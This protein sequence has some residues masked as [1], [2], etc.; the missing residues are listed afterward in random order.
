M[1]VDEGNDDDEKEDYFAHGQQIVLHEDKQYYPEA[2]K[3]FGKGVE[4]LVMEEDAQPLD[5]PIIAPPK[6]ANFQ[7]YERDALEPTYSMEFLGSMS[8]KADLTRSIAICGHLHNGKTLLCDMIVR[9]THHAPAAHKGIWD[10]NREY[11]W[12][13]NRKDEVNRQI[14]L[15]CSPLT[16][17]LED[18]REK[19]YLFNFMD[20]PGHP[21]FVD[22]VAA[23]MRLSD[24]VVILVDCIEGLTFYIERLIMQA[25]RERLPFVIVLNKLDRLVLELK[26]P[27]SD[28][29][30]K[31]KHTLDDINAVIQR[32]Q[33]IH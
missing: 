21:C 25:V 5:V 15:K 23:A 1:E 16:V 20:T 10:L 22:E 27:P 24:G 6:Q 14:S 12:T 19:S 17:L 33:P 13:D 30:Y 11:K 9:Q 18:S 26:L 8:A 31:I 29:Y 32:L 2:E 4:A 3:V 28:A 7:V